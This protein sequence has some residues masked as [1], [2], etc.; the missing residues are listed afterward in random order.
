MSY[1]HDNPTM[2]VRESKKESFRYRQA[3]LQRLGP[4]SIT[5]K[6]SGDNHLN[7]ADLNIIREKSRQTDR[8]NMFFSSILDRLIENV[9]GNGVNIQIQS[10]NK[11]WDNQAEFLWSEFWGNKPEVRNFCNGQELESLMFRSKRVDG[12]ILVIMLNDQIQ[13]IEGDRIRTPFEFAGNKNI[14]NGIELNAYGA[15]VRYFVHDYDD[16]VYYNNKGTFKTYE[17]KD[18][19]FWANRH[20]HS[21]TRGIPVLAR[22]LEL[23]DDIDGFV[24][25][26]VIQQKMAAAHVMFIT[27]KGGLDMLDGV[28]TETDDMGNEYQSKD[29]RPGE[30]LY[31]EPG[32]DAKVL[33]PQQ[34]GQQFSPFVSQLLRFAGLCFG[35]PLELVSLDFSRTNYSS[36]RASLLVAHKSFVRQHRDFLDN[37]MVPIVKWFIKS[38]IRSGEL[39]ERFDYKINATPPKMISVDPLK[40]TKAE[41]ERIAAG[42]S[43]L[44]E[45]ALNNGQ[46]WDMILAQKEIE[47]IE[48]ANIAKNI[49]TK[50]GEDW[51]ARDILGTASDFNPDIYE[52]PVEQTPPE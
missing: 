7:F 42:L 20:R 51:S 13:F 11:R 52:Q 9:I 12:D 48:A 32:E 37:V 17:A 41:I 40:E 23:F 27:R 26:S 49:V 36:A 50:T 18:C 25:A 35:M 4:Q 3:G 19:I 44:K 28:T 10:K 2:T 38:K 33:G 45:S 8:D 1:I 39:A 21:M 43:T 15:P 30:V 22:N 5:G 29:F 6:G 14:V 46:D 16:S 24:E 34:S 31:G 47:I